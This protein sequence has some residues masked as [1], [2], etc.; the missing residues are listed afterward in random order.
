MPSMDCG[1]CKSFYEDRKIYEDDLVFAVI[2]WEPIKD[3]HVMI[4]PRRHVAELSGM[5]QEEAHAALKLVDKLAS[6][7]SDLYED[8]PIVH[9]N[10][11]GHRTEGHIHIHV[12]PSKGSLRKHFVAHENVPLRQRASD[13]DIKKMTELIAS[14]IQ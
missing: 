3:G 4:L 14:K 1:L 2:N 7:L 12:I 10:C 6:A 11:G 13:E 9:V 8:T 5:T